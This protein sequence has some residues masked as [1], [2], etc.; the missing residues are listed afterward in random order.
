MA[1]NQNQLN[2]ILF[3]LHFFI[4]HLIKGI[5]DLTQSSL[6]YC[7]GNRILENR[8]QLEYPYFVFV[9]GSCSITHGVSKHESLVI[10]DLS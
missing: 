6:L 5:N 8:Q 10:L 2:C 9:I 7:I 4:A 1:F 3:S